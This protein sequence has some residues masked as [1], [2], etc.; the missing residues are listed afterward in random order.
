[1]LSNAHDAEDAF[2]ATFL[3]LARKAASIR[4]RESL[5][6]WL[7]GVAHR[8]A[9]KVKTRTAKRSQYEKQS[10]PRS[11]ADPLAEVT[12]RELVTVLDEEL[13]RLP[14]SCRAPLLLCYFQGKTRDEAALLLGWSLGTFKRRLEAARQRL[15]IRLARRG[16][17]LSVALPAL[18]T[19]Q[20]ATASTLPSL[21][22]GAT[23]R[24]ALQETAGTS[25]GV[26]ETVKALAD[27]AVR[28]LVG[29]KGKIV[30]VVLLV[31]GTLAL[32]ASTLPDPAGADSAT[33]P[34]PSVAQPFLAGVVSPIRFAP[35][36]K[37]KGDAK[38]LVSG[39]VL[40]ID[41]K[42]L[43]GAE[44]VL[45]GAW[46]PVRRDTPSRREVLVE[47]KS[48]KEGRYQLKVAGASLDQFHSLHVLARAT[49][50]GLGWYP[51]HRAN[52]TAE[53][54]VRLQPEQVVSVALIDLQG[55][56]AAGVKVHVYSMLDNKV[57]KHLAFHTLMHSAN[58]DGDLDGWPDVW[59]TSL[60][61]FP[62]R[63][64]A[65]KGVRLWPEAITTDAKGRFQ[66][67]GFGR[68]QFVH[69]LVEDERFAVQ[70]IVLET[71]SRESRNSAPI[72]LQPARHLEGRVVDA[73]TG[74]PIPNARLVVR[75][76]AMYGAIES[77]EAWLQADFHRPPLDRS[78]VRSDAQGR[79]RLRLAVGDGFFLQAFAPDGQ[80]YLGMEKS[81][82]FPRGT[83][84]QTVRIDL[85]RG[86]LVK[87]KVTEKGSGKPVDQ[88]EIHFQPLR[89]NNPRRRPGLLLGEGHSVF[90]QPDGSYQIIVPPQPGHLL[91]RIPGEPFL[92]QVISLSELMT[93]KPAA[94]DRQFNGRP[95]TDRLYFHAI[96]P[97][98]FKEPGPA[99][100]LPLTVR[101]GVTLI[102]RV[103]GPDGK[104]IPRAVMFCGGELLS[105]QK[106]VLDFYYSSGGHLG[107]AVPVKT[108]RSSCAAVI[109]RRPITSAFSRTSVNQAPT[110]AG[111]RSTRRS[112]S[113]RTV[114]APWWRSV[115][116]TWPAN[117]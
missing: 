89:E 53:A 40:S 4:K 28:S 49:G 38:I 50:Y 84:K 83:A 61:G 14:E 25:A 3:V 106:G 103:V 69:L 2:Q 60:G 17:T 81:I 22:A 10:L 15:G 56:S 16:L 76:S 72:V 114:A 110:V 27:S 55:Q 80:P 117:P 67:R 42:P 65:G 88:A 12:A 73:D 44:V 93:G 112:R 77:L 32:S 71:G 105:S 111:P 90:S 102:G 13:G 74:K 19:V 24:A 115:R 108:V 37:A 109:P 79:F 6:S 82:K 66:L 87:G 85:P 96:V 29:V 75:G 48:D 11:P 64:Y 59:E 52:A 63:E 51:V 86:T 41:G 70:R 78:E 36:I 97:L 101:R 8:V 46:R 39:R 68:N 9:I 57:N 7:H 62:F 92:Q 95:G 43:V 54:V 1:V 23:V 107:A 116:R 47:G 34:R 58:A 113:P 99:K 26:S 18:A 91:C 21:L 35:P 100:E 45:A 33:A 98:N 30:G 104:A 5:S 31:A 20:S 94:S